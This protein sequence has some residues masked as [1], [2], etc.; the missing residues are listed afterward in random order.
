MRY[1]TAQGG[2]M[3]ALGLGTWDL[4]GKECRQAVRHALEIGYEHIDTARMYANETA[5]GEGLAASGV[6]RDRVFV[7]TKVGP[8]A[9]A[10]KRLAAEAEASLRELGTDHVDLLLIHWPNPEVPLEE[11][12]D[13]MERLR[14][15]GKTRWIGVSNFPPSLFERAVQAAPVFC[16]QIEYH[17]FLSQEKLLR[18]ARQH[19]VLL[20]AYC[21]LAR[22]RVLDEPV[23]QEI[24]R[25][26]G[27]SA[28]QVTLRWLVQQGISAIPKAAK[29]EHLESNLAIFDFELASEEMQR[30][31]GLAREERLID[32]GFAPEWER[33]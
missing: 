15:A 10:P 7:T 1:L 21:P 20:T 24:G 17:P 22:G 33:G 18:A 5:V 14:K 31:S 25:E 26:H 13:A 4:R 3:P 32:P 12:L 28:A 8:E 6:A 27:K 29:R 16:N 23:L 2:R 11:T 9:L 30:I 19:D